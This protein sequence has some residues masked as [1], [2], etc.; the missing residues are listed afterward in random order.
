MKLNINV[1]HIVY[2]KEFYQYMIADNDIKQLLTAP[3]KHCGGWNH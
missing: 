1:F 2:L 3:F